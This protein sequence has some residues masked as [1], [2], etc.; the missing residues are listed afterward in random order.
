VFVVSFYSYKGGVGR[1]V[2][3]L[4]V[5]W[6]LAVDGH[7]VALLDLDLEA[8]GLHHARLEEHGRG[9]RA[10]RVSAGFRELAE[11]TDPLE[12]SRYVTSDLGPEGRISLIAASGDTGPSY[13][14]W[15]QTFR[16]RTFYQDGGRKRVEALVDALAG[17][18][19]YLL[20]DG[21]TGHTDVAS[22]TLRHLPDAIVFV[23]NLTGQSV[24]GIVAQLSYL[25]FF[26]GKVRE[27]AQKIRRPGRERAA[28]R[29]LL[30]ASQ[31]PHGE[32]ARRQAALK[33]LEQVA[34]QAPDV[35]IDHLPALAL[36]ESAQIVAPHLGLDPRDPALPAPLRPYRLIVDR[37][38]AMN[39]SAPENLLRT[40]EALLSIGRW[41][42]AL[43]HFDGAASRARDIPT[44]RE[45]ARRQSVRAALRGLDWRRARGELAAPQSTRHPATVHLEASW[46]TLILQ[47]L[48]ASVAQLDAALGLVAKSDRVEEVFTRY[49]L[50]D[51]LMLLGRWGEAVEALAA[52]KELAERLGGLPLM[53][54]MFAAALA[55]ARFAQGDAPGAERELEPYVEGDWPTLDRETIVYGRLL[56][57]RAELRAATGRTREAVTDVDEARRLFEAR[58]D[59]VA[60]LDSVLLHAS[61]CGAFPERDGESWEDVARDLDVPRARARLV[62]WRRAWDGATAGLS[63]DTAWPSPDEIE[64]DQ[65]L[66]GLRHWDTLRVWIE[67]GARPLVE[68]ILTWLDQRGDDALD[69]YLETVA[70]EVGAIL[71]L[72]T[73]AG[74]DTPTEPPVDD[75]RLPAPTRALVHA[76]GA[77]CA[78]LDGG[79][80]A[81]DF[82]SFLRDLLPQDP[83]AWWSSGLLRFLERGKNERLRPAWRVV[84]AVALDPYSAAS[85]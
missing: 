7:R 35:E 12:F 77:L 5:A 48:D 85:A 64:G 4:N 65:E 54:G 24:E 76:I 53:K 84:R 10:P 26:N 51:T 62:L 47:E 83:S 11:A 49:F 44:I 23:T 68:E 66:L 2:T 55:H 29:H 81:P 42:E 38:Y 20:I 31:L 63:E 52:G 60:L 34:E 58:G 80:I 33:A 3:L 56:L 82:A 78:V 36:D 37:L 46:T 6:Q 13:T 9:H 40:G 57:T 16:W 75:G 39:A 14:E 17:D 70:A 67:A 43:I 45:E 27:E 72:A 8:P 50:G 61:L 74:G 71:A 15:L 28:I 30:V 1:T 21:R 79:G 18:H 73:R 69:V 59:R 25:D 32:W 41:R 22:V 19:E